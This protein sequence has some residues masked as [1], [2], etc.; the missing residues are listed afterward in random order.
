MK[1]IDDRISLLSTITR[2]VLLFCRTQ[3]L[4]V[5]PDTEWYF[6]LFHNNTRTEIGGGRQYTSHIADI[7]ITAFHSCFAF[8]CYEQWLV[9]NIYRIV[10][11]WCVQYYDPSPYLGT[12]SKLERVSVQVIAVSS[13][14]R[15]S[16]VGR[17]AYET[18][19]LYFIQK[20]MEFVWSINKLILCLIIAVKIRMTLFR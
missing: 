17:L 7:V 6:I 3:Y 11:G 16:Y 8:A 15:S 5:K 19:F 18:R 14:G 2:D 20:L 1:F 10:I 9:I 12:A 13:G 4:Y